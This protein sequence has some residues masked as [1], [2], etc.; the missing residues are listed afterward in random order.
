M[1][2]PADFPADRTLA[3]VAFKQRQQ[4]QV[5]R[6][7]ERAVAAGVP[8][9]PRGATGPIPVAVVEIPLLSTQWRLVRRFIDGGMT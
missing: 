2:L 1:A 3:V 5:D 6:W 4:P 7:I 8:S 9:T